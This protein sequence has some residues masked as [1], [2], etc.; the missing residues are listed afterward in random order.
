[1]DRDLKAARIIE[2]E[3]CKQ[4]LIPSG[5]RKSTPVERAPL[6]SGLKEISHLKA[7]VLVETGSSDALAEE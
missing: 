6:L 2:I 1:M 3:G 4:F 5:R 7:R